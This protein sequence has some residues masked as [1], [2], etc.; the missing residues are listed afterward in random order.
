MTKRKKILFIMKKTKCYPK[1]IKLYHGTDEKNLKDILKNGL[2]RLGDKT[3]I[4]T[5]PK[6]SIARKYGK[7]VLEIEGKGLDLRVWET[8]QENQIMIMGDVKP[9]KIKTYGKK[10]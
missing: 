7:V 8:D 1:S 5:S 3:Y 10:T 9:E 6:K 4:Y 2:K